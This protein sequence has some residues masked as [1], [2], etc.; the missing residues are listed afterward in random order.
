MILNLK[1]LDK[2]YIFDK[3]YFLY[4]EEFDL[5]KSIID[6]GGFVYTSKDL[7]I[8]HLGFKSSIGKNA[9]VKED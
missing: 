9:F 7:K 5:C 3:K 1:K 2:K 4:F 6:K 8:H